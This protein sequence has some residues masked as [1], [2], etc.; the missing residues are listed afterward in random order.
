V[1]GWVWISIDIDLDLVASGER[2]NTSAH[3]FQPYL[4][5]APRSSSPRAGSQAGRGTNSPS[6]PDRRAAGDAETSGTPL[7][8]A[9]INV[10]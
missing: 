8:N 1:A 4:V 2:P 6:A 5:P 9:S 10:E 7:P 3:T